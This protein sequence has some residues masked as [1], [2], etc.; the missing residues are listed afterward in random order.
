MTRP[1]R[2]E[3]T[4]QGKLPH[5]TTHTTPTKALLDV[6]VLGRAPRCLRIG[7]Y[8]E[9]RR[10]VRQC[11]VV[12]RNQNT[13]LRLWHGR[14]L[15][16]KSHALGFWSPRSFPPRRFSSPFLP[17]SSRLPPLAGALRL[18]PWTGKAE[19]RR[20]V[21][22]SGRPFAVVSAAWQTSGGDLRWLALRRAALTIRLL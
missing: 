18:L 21:G 4:G 6:D 22:W 15:Q 13:G 16:G 11:S 8:L 5:K 9:Y 1:P 14:G 19:G 2:D 3:R 12:S 17:P 20:G 7:Q 10:Q